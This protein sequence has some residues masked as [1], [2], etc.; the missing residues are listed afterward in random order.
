[1]TSANSDVIFVLSQYL[2][3]FEKFRADNTKIF[4]GGWRW[5][6]ET[7]QHDEDGIDEVIYIPTVTPKRLR[8]K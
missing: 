6:V 7:G 5:V 3:C 2:Q 8:E 1:M 4:A